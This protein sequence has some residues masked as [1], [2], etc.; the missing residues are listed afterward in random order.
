MELEAEAAEADR[1][2]AIAV[3]EQRQLQKEEKEREDERRRR[4]GV[5]SEEKVEAGPR[6]P[7]EGAILTRTNHPH[8]YLYIHVVS[9]SMFGPD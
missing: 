5:G 7:R 2:E 8:K 1:L 4:E 9:L 6:V 3:E